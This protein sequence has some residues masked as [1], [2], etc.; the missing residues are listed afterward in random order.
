MY[1]YANF[2]IWI[3][4]E[5]LHI[6]YTLSI[7]KQPHFLFMCNKIVIRFDLNIDH[8]ID[9]QSYFIINVAVECLLFQIEIVKIRFMYSFCY[10]VNVVY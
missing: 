3:Y 9:Q 10:F 2:Q 5:K 4:S 6:D 7:H 1:I 8:E